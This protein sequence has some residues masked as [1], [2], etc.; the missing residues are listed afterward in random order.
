VAAKVVRLAP[1]FARLFGR[2]QGLLLADLKVCCATC[3]KGTAAVRDLLAWHDAI[4][5]TDW[6]QVVL[7]GVQNR[8][9]C[10]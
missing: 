4:P 10:L 6:M 2:A 5:E 1:R 8:G 7:C 3:V 9:C